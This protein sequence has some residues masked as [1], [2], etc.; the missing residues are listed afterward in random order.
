MSPPELRIL[1]PTSKALQLATK[2]AAA[3]QVKVDIWQRPGS[4]TQALKNAVEGQIPTLAICALGIITRT[5]ATCQLPDK[6]QTAPLICATESGSDFIPVLAGHQGANSLASTLATLCQGRAVLT[7][8]SDQRFAIALDQPPRGWTLASRPKCFAAFMHNLLEQGA[9]DLSRAPVWVQESDIPHDPTSPLKIQEIYGPPLPT[10][11]QDDP[12]R[13]LLLQA[14]ARVALGLGCERHCPPA[15][16]EALIDQGEQ[17][18]GFRFA[19]P[20]LAASIDLKVDEAAFAEIAPDMRFFPAQE[21]AAIE[22]PNPSERVLA[23]VGTASVAEAAALA[24]AGQGAKLILEK[25]KNDKATLAVA[26]LRS[27]EARPSLPRTST[28][29]RLDLVGLGPGDQALLS[30]QA[31]E[32]LHAADLWVG[33]GL[34]LDQAEAMLGVSKPRLNFKLGDEEARC[35]AALEAAAAGKRV[36]LICSGDPQIYAMAQVVYELLARHPERSAWQRLRVETVPGITAMQALAAKVGAPLGHDFCVL[37]LSD[38]NTPWET[39]ERKVQAAAQA[40]FVV[41]FYNPRSQKRD[42]QLPRA[43]DI[44]SAHRPG[45]CPVVFGRNVSRPD[46]AITRTT[47][48]ELDPR[49]I[50]MFTCLI[51]GASFTE[52]H[53]DRI[54]TPRGYKLDGKL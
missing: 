21:L 15:H 23:E 29:P 32:A 24:L 5:L 33:Y 34:Y 18:L 39:I 36:A 13:C 6:A 54:F 22:V 1:A 31:R 41:G 40:D 51:V 2:I 20:L 28:K 8:V 53:G 38:L 17:A 26:V 45:D 16:L 19:R 7:T 47:L 12:D 48:A 10:K 11:A 43:L 44:L 3:D 46:E 27:V 52:R 42:W 30:V 14:G 9:A 25:I 50:D 37:S 4:L 35:C 49:A